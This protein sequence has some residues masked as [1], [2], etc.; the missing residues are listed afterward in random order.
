[1]HANRG[2][3]APPSSVPWQF[4]VRAAAV[5]IGIALL[6]V[7]EVNGVAYYAAWA[8]IAAGLLSEGAATLVYY[9]RS[10]RPH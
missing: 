3:G 2:G 4:G 6:L 10:R 7:V 1:V 8:L 9:R 5:L